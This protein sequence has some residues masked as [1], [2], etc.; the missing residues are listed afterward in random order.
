MNRLNIR[1]TPGQGGTRCGSAGTSRV[2]KCDE[3]I[4]YQGQAE[5]RPEHEVTV[6]QATVE[7]QEDRRRCFVYAGPALPISLTW[8][9]GVVAGAGF[10]IREQ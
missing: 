9:H 6:L 4:E 10:R 2:V 5:A 3:A 1:P 7:Q 8:A